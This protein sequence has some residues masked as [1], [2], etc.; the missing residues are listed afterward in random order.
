MTGS[1]FHFFIIMSFNLRFSTFTLILFI[2]LITFIEKKNIYEF[3][4]KRKEILNDL[5]LF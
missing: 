4:I 3:L 5:Q 1:T 2:K